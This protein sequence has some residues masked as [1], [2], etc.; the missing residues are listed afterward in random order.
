MFRAAFLPI[1]RSPEPYIG[2][3]TLYAEIIPVSKSYLL[4]LFQHIILSKC[5]ML[6]ILIPLFCVLHFCQHPLVPR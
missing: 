1:I 5:C 3:G 2:F 4:E 6:S